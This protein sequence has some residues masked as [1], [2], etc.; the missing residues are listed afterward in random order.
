MKFKNVKE[1]I[2]YIDG[3]YEE[4]NTSITEKTSILLQLSQDKNAE[5]RIHLASNLVLFDCTEI[6][7]ILYNMLFD[8]NRMVRLEAMDALSIGRQK[9]TIDK[10]KTMIAGE[11]RLIRSYAVYTLFN[12]IVNCYGINETA[13]E[14]YEK[15]VKNSF[16]N[17]NN[18]RVLVEYYRNQ[19]YIDADKG[20]QHLKES[21]IYAVENERYDL[22]WPLLHI[23]QDI[24][25]KKNAENIKNILRYEFD[26]LLPEPQKLADEILSNSVIEKILIIDWDN[27]YTSHVISL[28][29]QSRNNL[30][31]DI[32]TAGMVV[33]KIKDKEIQDFC[34]RHKIDNA[35]KCNSKRITN[36][37][38]YEHIVCINMQM[39]KSIISKRNVICFDDIAWNNDEQ[40]LGVCK[41]IEIEVLNNSYK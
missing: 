7:D 28:L 13:F 29:L 20:M 38:S 34:K 27:S 6:E 9:K 30:V 16:A 15:A 18:L 14:I 19:Y 21:Y 1:K 2:K 23:F 35:K 11:G 36:A 37:Y 25:N 39:D 17:E 41:I 31:A 10:I 24:Q 3:L 32:T 22:I 12:V 4:N 26:K 33:G 40:I 5:V 8:K